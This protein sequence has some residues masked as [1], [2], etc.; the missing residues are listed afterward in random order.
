MNG[1]GNATGS[2]NESLRSTE[3]RVAKLMEEDMGSAMQ[4]LQGKGLCLMPISLATAISSSTTHS[5]GALFNPTSNIVAA[6]DANV[7][8]KAA[9][10][11]EASSTMDDVSTS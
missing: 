3:Q 9:A 2:S 4:Y 6:E 11:P 7:A 1:N 10:V 8:P 5:R